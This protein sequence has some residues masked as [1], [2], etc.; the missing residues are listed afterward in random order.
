MLGTLETRCCFV[1]D[2]KINPSILGTV[3]RRLKVEMKPLIWR[4][5]THFVCS[6]GLGLNSIA[7]AMVV[8]LKNSYPEITLTFVLPSVEYT[9]FGSKQEQDFFTGISKEADEIVYASERTTG[10]S[11]QNCERYIIDNAL[12][13]ICYAKNQSTAMRAVGYARDNRKSVID[14]TA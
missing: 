4:G 12:Y 2:T 13:C 1:S 8:V 6:T 9:V 11:V 3:G 5:I 7:A 10:Q 14:L